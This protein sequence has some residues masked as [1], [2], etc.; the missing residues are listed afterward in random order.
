MKIT[1]MKIIPMVLLGLFL[2]TLLSGVFLPVYSD[3]AVT[4]WSVSRFFLEDWKLLS[5]FPQCTE[6]TN[7]LVSWVFYPAGILLSFLYSYLEPLGLRLSG[8]ALSLVWFAVLAAWCF[9]QTNDYVNAL[10]R[11][12]GLVAFSALGIMPY[13][14][15]LS[16]P[17]QL[18]SLPV[19]IFCFAAFY[20]KEIKSTGWQ[21]AVGLVLATLLS[22]F[23]Y[24]H[25]KSLF[26][27]P[28]ILAVIWLATQTFHRGIRWFLILFTLALSFQVYRD[29]VTLTACA[30]APALRATFAANTL[31]PGMLFSA[32]MEFIDAIYANLLAFP[33]RMLQ[34]LTFNAVSQSGWLPPIE[35]SAPLLVVLNI[36]IYY[37]IYFLVAA[38][39]FAAFL[40]FLIQAVRLRVNAPIVLAMLLASAD[41]INVLFFNI[42][43]FYAGTQFVP[44]SIILVALLLQAL[45][46]RRFKGRVLGFGYTLIL[47]SS[48][49]SLITLLTIVTPA[50]VRNASAQQS[51][52]PGQPLSIPVLG[53][54]EHLQAIKKLS[55]ACGVA[56][57]SARSVVLDH[58][59]YFAFLQDKNPIHVLYVSEL[60]F[61][62]DLNNGK[63]FPFL[64]SVGS[65]GVVTRCEWIPK[66]FKGA[67]IE[68]E[69]GYCCVNLDKVQ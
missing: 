4:K 43:N 63:L 41:F 38:S 39:H 44:M 5:F 1:V 29:S 20:F 34:H 64:K 24:A 19:L 67:Q 37:G 53:V 10:Q 60:G 36:I 32:P 45:P 69:M 46:S 35:T 9:K 12:A 40:A 47:L 15:V 50:V 48:A 66:E 33:E 27:A 68:G 65:P 25:P 14:W 51:S 54:D 22:C 59:T 62:Q 61:G 57:G 13:L 8:I 55:A 23:F 52:L 30:N 6:S 11:F 56:P 3:E 58:M 16:R 26:F 7:R 17:E 31:M 21:C 18:M 2:C 42:Q 49:F 28:F